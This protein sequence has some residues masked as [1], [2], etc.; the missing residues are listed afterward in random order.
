MI[1]PVFNGFST[2]K[3]LFEFPYFMKSF[4]ISQLPIFTGISATRAVKNCKSAELVNKHASVYFCSD[5]EQIR[6]ITQ[7]RLVVASSGFYMCFTS[8]TRN[9]R[10]CAPVS[11]MR[12][13]SPKIVTDGPIYLLPMRGNAAATSVT[14]IKLCNKVNS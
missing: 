12:P 9:K 10:F 14:S 13:V 5:P 7:T 6:Q 3:C 4:L 2:V 11:C 1:Q 8:Q